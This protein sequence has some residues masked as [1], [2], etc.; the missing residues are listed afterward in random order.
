MGEY[1]TGVLYK[2][3][4]LTNTTHSLRICNLSPV[5]NLQTLWEGACDVLLASPSHRIALDV[6][7]VGAK[8]DGC[9]F[10]SIKEAHGEQCHLEFWG[11]ADQGT[12]HKLLLAVPLELDGEELLCVGVAVLLAHLT[13]VVQGPSFLLEVHLDPVV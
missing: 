11:C 12:A 3:I 13:L 10:L 5:N 1:D 4:I 8:S 9:V 2:S 7:V 6:Y